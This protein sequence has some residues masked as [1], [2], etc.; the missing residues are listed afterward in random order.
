MQARHELPAPIRI[1]RVHVTLL[2][3]SPASARQLDF[4]IN[5]DAMRQKWEK[6]TGALDGLNTRYGKTI[7]HVG[8]WVPP[9]GGYA[10]GKISYTRIPAAE[11][12]W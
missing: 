11:D 4:L 1:V 7:V 8:P 12:F 2:D 10:G 9:P 5:D 3:L 6:V